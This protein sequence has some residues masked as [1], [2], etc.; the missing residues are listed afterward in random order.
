LV[1]EIRPNKVLGFSVSEGVKRLA[2]DLEMAPVKKRLRNLRKRM[3][4]HPV[5]AI[6]GD[7]IPKG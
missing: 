1:T 7:Y 5:F 4:M 6:K 2:G 3:F